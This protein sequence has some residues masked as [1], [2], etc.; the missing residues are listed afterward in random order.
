MAGPDTAL[1]REQRAGTAVKDESV[2]C[3]TAFYFFLFPDLFSSFRTA[4]IPDAHIHSQ[5]AGLV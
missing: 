2:F 5:K 1:P 4:R 3:L